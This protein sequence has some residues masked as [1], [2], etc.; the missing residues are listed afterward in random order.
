[1]SKTPSAL[2]NVIDPGNSDRWSEL[3]DTDGKVLY[4]TLAQDG[5]VVPFKAICADNGAEKA[6]KISEEF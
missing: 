6:N 3:A 1:M 5:A 2:W 4:T